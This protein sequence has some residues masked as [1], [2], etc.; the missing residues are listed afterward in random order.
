M[1]GSAPCSSSGSGLTHRISPQRRPYAVALLKEPRSRAW[2]SAPAW[3]SR[4]TLSIRPYQYRR[5]DDRLVAIDD[6]RIRISRRGAAGGQGSSN[7]ICRRGATM[8]AVG[9]STTV[10]PP[11]PCISPLAHAVRAP[12]RKQHL[13]T[14]SGHPDT[15]DHFSR[16]APSRSPQVHVEA[17]G[18]QLRQTL[19][20]AP[21]DMVRRRDRVGQRRSSPR[22]A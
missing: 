1:V 22:S 20:V 5:V 2:I 11:Y 13:Q 14:E 10:V 12:T 6:E 8:H 15:S 16:S 17:L 18:D 4:R 9:S 19:R 3:T 21:A 7:R